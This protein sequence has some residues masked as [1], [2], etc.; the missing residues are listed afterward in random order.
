MKLQINGVVLESSDVK[1]IAQLLKELAERK[2]ALAAGVY[3][4][5]RKRW[6]PEEI[7]YLADN[8]KQPIIKLQKGLAKIFGKRR[9]AQAVKIALTRLTN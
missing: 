7:E 6:S 3:Q 9:T 1:E 2:E 8:K 5:T 4:T